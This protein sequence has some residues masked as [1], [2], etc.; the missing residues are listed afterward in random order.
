M[1]NA[2]MKKLFFINAAMVFL[3]LA[4]ELTSAED[5]LDVRVASH[6]DKSW[7]SRVHEKYTVSEVGSNSLITTRASCVA[8]G[9]G[10]EPATGCPASDFESDR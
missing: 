7:T 9:T 10:F 6:R 8:E 3:C 4:G 1:E 2:A 5:L